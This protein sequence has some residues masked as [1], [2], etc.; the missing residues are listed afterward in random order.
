MQR[1]AADGLFTKPSNIIPANAGIQACPQ[2]LDARLRGQDGSEPLVK[3]RKTRETP[4]PAF[5][6]K[7]LAEIAVGS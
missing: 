4:F 6:R 5:L 1:N 3:P 2:A 7:G